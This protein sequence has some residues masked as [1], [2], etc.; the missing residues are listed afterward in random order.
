MLLTFGRSLEYFPGTLIQLDMRQ[1]SW[2]I[3]PGDYGLVSKLP[4]ELKYPANL[5]ANCLEELSRLNTRL[6]ED[7]S[8]YTSKDCILKE[9]KPFKPVYHVEELIFNTELEDYLKI[10][11]SPK[12][13]KDAVAIIITYVGVPAGKEPGY[14]KIRNSRVASDDYITVLEYSNALGLLHEELVSHE[15]SEFF[16]IEATPFREPHPELASQEKVDRHIELF[17]KLGG[18]SLLEYIK[19]I[20]EYEHLYS[21]WLTDNQDA[22]IDLVKLGTESNDPGSTESTR[23]FAAFPR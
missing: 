19:Q 21:K 9:I 17:D 1:S 6:L 23:H 5:A 12:G 16:K 15:H 2:V 22:R 13:D 18:M 11:C 4:K 7:L 8:H 14:I 20:P 10:S 3:S